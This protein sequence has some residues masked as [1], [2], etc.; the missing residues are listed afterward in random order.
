MRRDTFIT[1]LTAFVKA[2]VPAGAT[3][4]IE[5]VD[6]IEPVAIPADHLL[7]SV[8]ADA[9]TAVV[10]TRPPLDM[11][12]ATTDASWFSA[13]GVP[14]LPALGPGLL[15]HAHARDEAIEIAALDQAVPVYTEVARRLLELDA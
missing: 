12:P 2:R 11:F 14:C 5:L 7:V 6:W 13:V 1:E 8:A 15:R 3:V 9:V 4:D 10:G